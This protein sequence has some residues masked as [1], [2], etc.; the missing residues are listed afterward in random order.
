MSY[1]A[2]ISMD[3]LHEALSDYKPLTIDRQVP[4]KPRHVGGGEGHN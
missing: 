4:R 2:A 3:I 1:R